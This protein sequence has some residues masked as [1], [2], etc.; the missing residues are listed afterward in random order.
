MEWVIPSKFSLFHD[1]FPS[2]DKAT[3]H[4]SVAVSINIMFAI[5]KI[6]FVMRRENTL[7]VA[8]KEENPNSFLKEI[9]GTENH[10]VVNLLKEGRGVGNYVNFEYICIVNFQ[11]KE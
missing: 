7:F 11:K 2:M 10:I 5:L 4:I 9:G 3:E 6:S 8:F 1:T